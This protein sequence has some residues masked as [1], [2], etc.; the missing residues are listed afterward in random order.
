MGNIGQS[1]IGD[2]PPRVK[3]LMLPGFNLNVWNLWRYCKRLPFICYRA[4]PLA[5][6]RGYQ[7]HLPITLEG[8]Q[9][10]QANYKRVVQNSLTNMCRQQQNCEYP[11]YRGL[12]I[13]CGTYNNFIRGLPITSERFTTWLP[14]LH[15]KVQHFFGIISPKNIKYKFK[16]PRSN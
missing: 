9:C 5:N 3:K 1:K 4:N 13:H 8:S 11:P 16:K 7:F 6:V 12:P 14:N 15:I 10:S 2:V